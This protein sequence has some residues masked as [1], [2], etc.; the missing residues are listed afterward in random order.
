MSSTSAPMKESPLL[1]DTSA[2]KREI[3]RF[4]FS[5]PYWDASRDKRLVLQ[6]CK[7]ANKF[8]HYPRPVSIYTGR[9]RDLEW[10]EVSGK[11]EIFTFTI[12]VRGLTVFRG[13]EP[14]A[15]GIVRLD[16]GVNVM[17]NVIHCRADELRIGM[18]MKPCW[19]PLEDG[20]NLLM[21]EPDVT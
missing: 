19:Q 5:M 8:Q 1:N 10:R 7:V 15:V 12:A 11:G 3:R 17:A 14:Y 9:R 13:H 21:F 18:R 6:Y 4:G 20:T 16:E 2:V